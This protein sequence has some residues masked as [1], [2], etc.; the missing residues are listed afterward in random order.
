MLYTR[1]QY[2]IIWQLY[3][4]KVHTYIL[5]HA[6]TIKQQIGKLSRKWLGEWALVPLNL[7]QMLILSVIVTL[8]M[9]LNFSGLHFLIYK[10]GIIMIPTS[11]IVMRFNEIN[12]CKV[13]RGLP[14]PR[15]GTNE[16]LY[17]LC[18]E[19]ISVYLRNQPATTR[20]DI[21]RC[22]KLLIQ[23]V[24]QQISISQLYIKTYS[25]HRGYWEKETKSRSLRAFHF[26][27]FITFLNNNPQDNDLQ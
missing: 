5:V 7:V 3:L 2:N 14:D 10:I 24:I 26:L 13:F 23:S 16:V 25:R 12:P 21:S 6:Y 20:P 11:K 15:Q 1:N 17:L 18:R 22:S 27:M 4:N 9:R 8:D 19:N